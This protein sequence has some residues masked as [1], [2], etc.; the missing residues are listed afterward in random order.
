MS[1]MQKRAPE[2]AV[3]CPRCG[4]VV[5]VVQVQGDRCTG[6]GAEFAL[7]RPGEEDAANDY[8]LV[9]TGQKDVVTLED[10]TIVIVHD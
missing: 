10:G 1:G 3:A 8:L 7:F 9:L 6:C 2:V 5:V 4:A